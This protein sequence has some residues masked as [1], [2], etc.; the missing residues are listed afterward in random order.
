MTKHNID[1]DLAM[2]DPT[3]VFAA[4]EDVFAAD[5][6]GRDTKIEILRRWGYDALELEVA[7]AEGMT[8]GKIDTLDRVLRALKF[9]GV[10]PDLEHRPPTRQGGI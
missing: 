3:A 10:E 8:D 5:E 6:L 7:E 1:I 9:L 4:P 2:L